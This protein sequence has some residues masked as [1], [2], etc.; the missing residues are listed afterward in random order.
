MPKRIDLDGGDSHDEL[1]EALR[2]LQRPQRR[3]RPSQPSDPSQPGPAPETQEEVQDAVRELAAQ[4]KAA[5]AAQKTRA[6]RPVWLIPVIVAAVVVIVAV[7]ALPMLRP[8]P[9]PPPA[10]TAQGAVSGFWQCLIEGKYEAATVYCPSMVEKYGSRKQAA[11][12]LRETFGEN[13][14]VHLS[15]VGDPEQLPD[16]TDLRV[17]YEIYLRSGT[18][19]SGDAIVAS[20]GTAYVIVAGI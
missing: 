14:P 5:A 12:R 19:R 7:A 9:L 6:P 1:E 17:S 2:Q 8:E 20:S 16:S 4:Q 15:K 18:P 3:Q 13:P 11:E 10:I